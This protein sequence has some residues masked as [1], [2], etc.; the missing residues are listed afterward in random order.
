MSSSIIHICLPTVRALL[1]AL[2]PAE[3]V[4]VQGSKYLG[5]VEIDWTSCEPAVSLP[6]ISI[7]LLISERTVLVLRLLEKLR[8]E[9]Y[10]DKT[11]ETQHEQQSAV[12]G[13]HHPDLLQR[14][15]CLY[16]TYQ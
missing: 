14:A 2:C 6:D 11:R 10:S 16:V 8:T 3:G 15:E 7:S 1:D 12:L 9:R 5:S 13:T 4:G